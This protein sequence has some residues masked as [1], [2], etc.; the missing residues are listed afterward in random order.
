M[1]T[2]YES[3]DMLRWFDRWAGR[4]ASS[5][6]ISPAVKFDYLADAQD[7]V[8]Q[9]IAAVSAKTLFAAPYQLTTADGGLTFTYGTDAN[10][11]A[12][13]PMGQT[14]IYPTTS[15]I[16]GGAWTPGVDYLDEGTTI[17]MP[18][19]VPYTGTLFAYGLQMAP[20]MSQ[21][22]QPV[23]MPPSIR[24]LIPRR[25]VAM[26]AESGNIRNEALAN[27]MS[28]EFEKEFGDTMTLLRK[29][30]KT[31]GTMGRMLMPW[32]VGP[33]GPGWSGAW[34]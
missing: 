13:F 24:M 26:F 7:Y 14:G 23:L 30:V 21:D 5:D 9:R 25:A 8:I 3:S 15:S 1:S 17:R 20:R 28:V 32:G 27:R 12:L 10:G 16:P 22:V 31:S 4:N 29:H 34:W 19:A 18:N 33:Y 2:G 11:Y 6:T